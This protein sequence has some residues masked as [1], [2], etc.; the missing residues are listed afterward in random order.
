MLPERY[1][2]LLTGYVDGELSARQRRHALRLLRRS[3]EARRL[4]QR[5][6]S[7]SDALIHLP[8]PRL[9]RD[10]SAPVLHKI[11]AA[12]PLPTRPARRFAPSRAYPA[13]VGAAAAA[14]VLFVVGTA[15]Y[16]FFSS[17]RHQTAPAVAQNRT[18]PTVDVPNMRPPADGR[19]PSRRRSP[20]PTPGPTPRLRRARRWPTGRLISRSIRPRRRSPIRTSRFSRLL[21]WRRSPT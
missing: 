18:N 5:L 7:D 4:L 20:H 8:K 19:T 21:S 9:D 14:A 13:W 1:R 3:A 15:S 10:L 2:E 11:A 16:C 6:Q 17:L 12:R